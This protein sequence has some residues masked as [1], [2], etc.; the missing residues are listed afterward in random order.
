M[1]HSN[2]KYEKETHAYLLVNESFVINCF[3]NRC[4][5]QVKRVVTMRRVLPA[6]KT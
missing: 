5:R 6:K 3:R 1:T 4:G 2:L